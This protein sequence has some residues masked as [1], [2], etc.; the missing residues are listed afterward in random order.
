MPEMSAALIAATRLGFAARQ[1][2]LAAIGRDPRGWALAQLSRRAAPLPGDLPGSSVMVAAEFE[3]HRDKRDDPDAKR[4]FNQRVKAVYLAEIAARTQAATASDAPLLERLCHF[5]SNHF[6]VSIQRPAIHG[7]AAAFEREAIRPHVTG[8]FADMLLAVARHPAM[9]LY[10]DNAQSIGPDSP[11]GMRRDK[12]LN[13]NLGRELLE[14]HTLGVDGGYTQADVEALAR[15]LTGWSV[16]QLRDPQPGGFFFRP[17]MHEPGA[18]VLLGRT[19]AEGGYA[20]G[21]AALLA[22]AAHPATARHVAVKLA[23]H[24]IADDPPKDSVERIALV[25]RSSGGDLRRVTEAVVREDALW[26]QPFAKLRTPGEMVIAACRVTGFSPP[27]EML[28]GSL[29]LL[30]HLPFAAPSPAG[31]P[32]A[33]ADWVSPEAVL[34]RAE[35]CQSF[36]ERL[37][38]PPDPLELAAAAY[39]DALPEETLQAIRRAPSRRIGVA[40]LL[41]SPHFQRR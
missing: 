24:F 22:L 29:R 31:W 39:G 34:R 10:L 37:P 40:L 41:A 8:R 13:E 38:E 4:D 15:I 11:V 9:L 5:W 6:T 25:F 7:L 28:V 1:G 12:G 36:A 2:D 35:W 21:E 3:F 16:A 32:D 30:D 19:Y 14:L 20:E 23:R 17:M 33:A 26:R 27:P 18:K